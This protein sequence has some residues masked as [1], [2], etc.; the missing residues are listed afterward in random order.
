MSIQVLP[1]PYDSVLHTKLFTL[2]LPYM[3]GEMAETL[4][5]VYQKVISRPIKS[6]WTT[7]GQTAEARRITILQPVEQKPH[8]QKDRQDEKAEGY[9]PDEGTI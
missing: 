1:F 8:S 3:I 4:D 6:L 2:G 9:V 5:F 7:R